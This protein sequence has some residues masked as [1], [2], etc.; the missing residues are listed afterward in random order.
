MTYLRLALALYAL[1]FAGC[2]DIDLDP[3]DLQYSVTGTV[4]NSATN[5]PLEGVKVTIAGRSAISAANGT[6]TVANLPKATLPY[7]AEKS[8]SRQP[9]TSWWS[10]RS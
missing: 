6:Y 1:S 7:T 2:T 9:V 5:A 4:R 3:I 8:G 10:T